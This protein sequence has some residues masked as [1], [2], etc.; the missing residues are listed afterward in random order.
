MSFFPDRESP[1]EEEFT[2]NELDSE[3]PIKDT[4]QS[5]F[6]IEEVD[7][8]V[9][10]PVNPNS[11]APELRPEAY[12]IKAVQERPAVPLPSRPTRRNYGEWVPGGR[13]TRVE[14]PQLDPEEESKLIYR[15]LKKTA[16]TIA[17]SIPFAAVIYAVYVV[18]HLYK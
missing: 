16:G 12:K 10:A 17:I 14:N 18:L 15:I 2:E 4:F 13:S 8:L 6:G 9:F 7:P 5:P 1:S 3:E 11:L